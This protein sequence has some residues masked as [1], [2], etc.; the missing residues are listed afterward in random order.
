MYYTSLGYLYVYLIDI[1]SSLITAHIG[2]I[3]TDDDLNNCTPSVLI[4]SVIFPCEINPSNSLYFC[5]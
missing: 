4:S 1:G 5:P 3:A 2:H